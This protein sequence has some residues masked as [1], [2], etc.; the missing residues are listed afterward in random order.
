MYTNEAR[1]GIDLR[2]PRFSALPAAHYCQLQ[3][4]FTMYATPLARDSKNLRIRSCFM[5]Q[6]VVIK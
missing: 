3:P 1:E 2:Q 6:A 4:H 5:R